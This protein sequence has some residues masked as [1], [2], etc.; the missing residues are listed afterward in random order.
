MVLDSASLQEEEARYQ[1]RRV[2]RHHGNHDADIEPLYRT[3]DVFNS[4]KYIG[5]SASYDQMLQ[6]APGNSVTFLDAGHILGSASIY[7]EQEE[8]GRHHRLLFSGNLGYS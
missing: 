5:R 3:L 2:Q 4:L 6:I 8:D 1:Q 7:L